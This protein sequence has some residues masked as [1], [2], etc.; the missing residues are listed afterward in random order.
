GFFW[1]GDLVKKTEYQQINKSCPQTNEQ[2]IFYMLVPDPNGTINGNSRSVSLVRQNTRGT[3][4]HEF[5]HMI[6]QGSRLLNPAVD[7]SE[8]A[9]LDESLSH[10]AE[11][12]VGRKLKGFGDFQNL[13]FANVNPNSA[14][15]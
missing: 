3:L 11:E 15:Q 1:G 10:F 7:S 6:N 2:E 14:N 9:W 13:T 5:Q 12:I 4:A 8:T